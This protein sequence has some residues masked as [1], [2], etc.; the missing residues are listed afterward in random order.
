MALKVD[1]FRMSFMLKDQYTLRCEQPAS[2]DVESTLNLLCT[3][4]SDLPPKQCQRLRLGGSERLGLSNWQAV[5][6]LYSYIYHIYK[7]G[8]ILNRDNSVSHDDGSAW[9]CL[10]LMCMFH[11]ICF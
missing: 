3:R 11:V 10:S 8:D 9:T 1:G 4:W 7:N 6:P 5:S 2:F